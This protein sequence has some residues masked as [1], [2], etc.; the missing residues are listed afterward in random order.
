MSRLDTDESD[1]QALADLRHERDLQREPR[2]PR[3]P[4]CVS[5]ARGRFQASVIDSVNRSKAIRI[6]CPHPGCIAGVY[7]P[8]DSHAERVVCSSCETTL[9][10]RRTIDGSVALQEIEHVEAAAE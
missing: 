2:E 5:P 8:A 3:H 4:R 10:T 6:T 7:V 9:I 1:R